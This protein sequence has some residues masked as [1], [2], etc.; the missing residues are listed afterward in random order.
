[1]MQRVITHL[2]GGR[3]RRSIAWCAALLSMMI[4]GGVQSAAASVVYVDIVP[5]HVWFKPYFLDLDSD[6]QFDLL[7]NH[8][9]GCLGNCL[10]T[11]T[12]GG[13]NGA[14]ILMSNAQDVTAMSSGQIVG[15][16]A[17]S[18]GGSGLLAQDRFF[19]DPPVYIDEQ[20]EWDNGLTAFAG[21]RFSNASGQHYG[22]VRAFVQETS[23][24]L[25][26]F[27]YAYDDTPDRAIAAAS[28]PEPATLL[29]ILGG[30]GAIARRR[31]RTTR[32]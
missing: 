28:V 27:D 16:G 9:F 20:G 3:R 15:P 8:D 19:G 4:V 23:N 14:Q 21:F 29:L 11:A 7:F 26:I 10:S 18:F 5:D 12:L 17:S 30:A 24:D 32:R 1:M 22:W 31:L 13:L 6:G 2:G 25:V